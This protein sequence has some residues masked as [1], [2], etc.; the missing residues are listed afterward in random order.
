VLQQPLGGAL[1]GLLGMS[2][3]SRFDIAIKP[4]AIQISS[5]ARNAAGLP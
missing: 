3:L 4:G 1:D 2:F 5:R